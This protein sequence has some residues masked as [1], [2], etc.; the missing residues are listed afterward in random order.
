MSTAWEV[1]PVRKL[2]SIIRYE[3]K[4][5]ITR[6][7]TW[8]VFLIAVAVSLLD[9]F[10]S[11]GNLHRLEF[12]PDPVYFASRTMSQHGLLLAFGLMV[13]L[14][15]RFSADQKTGVKALIM[16][17]PVTRS[18]YILGKNFAG[19]VYAVTVFSLFLALN[20]VIYCLSAPFQVSIGT[21][22]TAVV[23]TIIIC[24]LPVSAFVGFLAVSLPGLIDVRL[25]Y[26]LTAILFIASEST[27]GTAEAM[28]FYCI[29]SGDLVKLIWHHPKWEFIDGGSVLANLAFL[30]GSGLLPTLLLLAKRSFWRGE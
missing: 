20:A 27:V 12:L 19:F 9:D 4:M 15:N 17:S 16:A 8:G 22:V 10:P 13:L 2:L 23:K 7:A 6:I 1:K 28:P 21:L 14:S 30:L 3:Y 18:Q 26:A 29:T 25:F 5:Q 24:V 11:A